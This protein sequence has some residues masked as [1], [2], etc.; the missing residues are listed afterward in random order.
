MHC[1][2]FSQ[3]ATSIYA[4]EPGSG[5]SGCMCG[6]HFHIVQFDASQYPVMEHIRRTSKDRKELLST[7]NFARNFIDD[8]LLPWGV[9]RIIYMDVDTLVQVTY[10]NLMYRFLRSA[11]SASLGQIYALCTC[12]LEVV[13]F[14]DT[15]AALYGRIR[16]YSVHWKR[17]FAPLRPFESC[18][19]ARWVPCGPS[20]CCSTYL[21]EPY[22]I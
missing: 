5:R 16:A 20:V 18:S 4:F 7:M 10:C 22:L 19:P 6:L 13:K 14:C 17:S 1:P 12:D 15:I 21:I 8:I 11:R 2:E 3:C 9:E